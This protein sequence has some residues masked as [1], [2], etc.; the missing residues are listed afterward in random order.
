LSYSRGE[1]AQVLSTNYICHYL[2]A[3]PGPENISILA[4]A[5]C[6]TQW[7]QGH[8]EPSGRVWACMKN[9]SMLTS[10]HRESLRKQVSKSFYSELECSSN[11]EESSVTTLP[12]TI[13]PP[14]FKILAHFS[15]YYKE[16]NSYKE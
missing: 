6:T 13:L 3:V 15:N 2:R 8:S 16:Q 5:Y 12:Y 10:G 1:E 9:L 11:V 14:L 7:A 4:L